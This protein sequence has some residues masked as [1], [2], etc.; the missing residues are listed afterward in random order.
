MEISL[1]LSASSTPFL[2][3]LDGGSA[4]PKPPR[5]HSQLSSRRFPNLCAPVG[6]IQ[7]VRLR[8]QVQHGPLPGARHRDR[9]S[10]LQRTPAPLALFL[11]LEKLNSRQRRGT[12]VYFLSQIR[13]CMKIRHI[14]ACYR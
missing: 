2:H 9:R 1:V 8:T 6:S 3:E 5:S 11:T 7:A 4:P 12:S 10:A 14:L 13:R